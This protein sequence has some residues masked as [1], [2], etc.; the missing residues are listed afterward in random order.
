M[1]TETQLVH[2]LVSI[3]GG[4]LLLCVA[5]AA[6]EKGGSVW[7]VGAESVAMASA[8]PRSGQTMV[9]EYTCFY[10]ANE[11]DDAH[12]KKLPLPDFKL[13]VFAQ[14]VKL[15][16]NWGTQFLGGEMVSYVAVPNVY[17]QLHLPNGKFTK[18]ALSNINLVPIEVYYHRKSAHWFYALQFE[19]EGSGYEP[20]S[21]LN[22]GQHNVA[23]TPAAGFT[24]TPHHGE[25]EISSRFDYVI[26]NA[27][28]DTHYHSGNEFF[29]QFDARQEIPHH[30]MTV[31]LVGYYYQQITD[32]HQNGKVF[33]SLNADGT[34]NSGNRGRQLDFGPQ[35]TFPF[36]K[37]GGLA[38]KWEHDMLVQNKPRGN[39]FWFQFGIPFSMLHH[40]NAGR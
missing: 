37:H 5:S 20:G 10:V 15:S 21:S 35:V 22:I 27:D 7:P 3:F 25:Q 9:Y 24:L 6:T 34:I 4:V 28:H 23:L 38:I 19:T 8:V 32:D 31:G 29:W 18:D 40:P 11:L 1:R 2:R 13:R 33:T 14:A 16:H 36:G 39:G 17:Q 12:G 30:R 26:N